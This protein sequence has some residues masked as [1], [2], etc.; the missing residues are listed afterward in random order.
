MRN[1]LI[2]LSLVLIAVP[3]V[4]QQP[5]RAERFMRQCDDYWGDRDQE[6]FCD[7]RETTIKAPLTRLYVDGRDNGGI[8]FNGWDK[9]EVL[10]RALIQTTADT[11]KEA[12]ALAKDIKIETDGDRIRADGPV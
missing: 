6:R 1:S 11:R 4:A 8:Y 5:S 10:V 2:C 3:L 7:I 12:E 9:N